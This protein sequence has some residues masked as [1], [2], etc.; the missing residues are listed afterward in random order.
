MVDA[1]DETLQQYDE[2]G[3]T[4]GVPIALTGAAPEF[5][6]DASGYALAN[7]LFRQQIPGTSLAVS[8]DDRLCF[9]GS[10]D[11]SIRVGAPPVCCVLLLG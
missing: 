6:G 10:G 9:S 7:V 4:V 5:V 8:A 1:T 11:K 3:A 2:A